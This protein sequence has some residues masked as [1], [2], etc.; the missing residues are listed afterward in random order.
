M[1]TIKGGTIV[2]D[3]KL[4]KR[5]GNTLRGTMRPAPAANGPSGGEGYASGTM[6]FGDSN[7]GNTGTMM[8]PRVEET[9]SSKTDD[10]QPAFMK[11]LRQQQSNN[12]SASSSSNAKVGGA[13]TPGITSPPPMPTRPAG[14]YDSVR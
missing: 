2:M 1:S 5:K 4:V 12:S 6:V 8:L 14:I 13:A 9:T 11:H 7:P 3:G 10:A